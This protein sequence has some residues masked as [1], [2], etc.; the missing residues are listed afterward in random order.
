V[1]PIAS[2]IDSYIWLIYLG[3]RSFL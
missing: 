1:P 3:S 2:V